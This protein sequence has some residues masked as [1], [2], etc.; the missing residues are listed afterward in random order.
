MAKETPGDSAFLTDVKTLRARARKQ[1]ED[2]ALTPDYELDPDQAIHLLNNALATELVCVL[3]YRQHAI[4]AT[5][6]HSEPI[7]A[8]FLVHS[9][10]ELAHADL[11]AKRIVQLGGTP[12]MDPAGLTERS[13]SEYVACDDLKQMIRENLVAERIAIEEQIVSLTGK[14]DEGAKTVDATGF[15]ITVTG[16]ISRKMDW[17]AWETVKAQIPPEMHPVKLKPE[18]DEK[19]VKWLADNQPDIY[20]LLPITV[21]PAKTAVPG[22][23]NPSI[24]RSVHRLRLDLADTGPGRSSFSLSPGEAS[25]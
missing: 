19:G 12:M 7:A 16:K 4:A 6:I 11:L 17:K 10:E 8:E 21:A 15:K 22:G 20:K 18:L 25:A 9:N 3:R 2:G 24:H 5:G 14:R 1:I 23:T 13:H